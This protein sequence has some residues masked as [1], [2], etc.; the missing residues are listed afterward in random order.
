MIKNKQIIIFYQDYGSISCHT[1][2]TI[3][4]WILTMSSIVSEPPRSWTRNTIESWKPKNNVCFFFISSGSIVVIIDPVMFIKSRISVVLSRLSPQS[5]G[6]L[7]NYVWIFERVF[8]ISICPLRTNVSS[9][10]VVICRN[11]KKT[12]VYADV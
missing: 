7:L 1:K 6:E 10:A 4:I 12:K 3:I 8:I 5:F 11:E 2:S 9:I